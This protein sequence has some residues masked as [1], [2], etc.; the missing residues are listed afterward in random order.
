MEVDAGIRGALPSLMATNTRR[1]MADKI[2]PTEIQPCS[3]AAAITAE[4]GIGRY[5]ETAMRIAGVEQVELATSWICQRQ[6]VT[7]QDDWMGK[8]SNT[9]RRSISG[10]NE[11]RKLKNLCHLTAARRLRESH[12]TSL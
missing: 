12:V 1:R 4:E 10:S 8:T 11:G 2:F 6:V 5:R 7:E 3:S 9:L